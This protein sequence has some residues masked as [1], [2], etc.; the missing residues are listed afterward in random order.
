MIYVLL[1]VVALTAWQYFLMARREGR[2]H[3]LREI[4]AAAFAGAAAGLLIGL[5]SRIGMAAI[6]LANGAAR[7]TFSGSFAVVVAFA[8]F[9][10]ILGIVYAGLFR[11]WLRESGLAFGCLLALC[12]WYPLAEAAVEDLTAKPDTGAL[13][14]ISGAVVVGMWVPYAVVLEK[15]FSRW[16]QRKTR[17]AIPEAA[18]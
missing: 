2:G 17:E 14:L 11:R 9:G 18:I 16:R 12:M 8:G 1:L 13:V 3:T 10:I 7:F 6:G 5:A 15:L 4:I